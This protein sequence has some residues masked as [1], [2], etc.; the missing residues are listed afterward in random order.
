MSSKSHIVKRALLIS[1]LERYGITSLQ[2]ISAIILARLL[3]PEDIG[4]YTVGVAVIGIAHVIRDFGV[5]QYL[6]QEKSLTREKVASALGLTMTFA[7]SLGAL[8]AVSAPY[9]AAYYEEPAVE[10]VLFVVVLNFLIIPL[11][12][13]APALLKRSMSFGTLFKINLAAATV[14][15]IVSI[16]LAYLGFG[17]MSMAWATVANVAVGALMSQIYLPKKYRVLPSLSDVK[18]ILNFGGHVVG[19]NIVVE[20][21]TSAT[22]LIVGKYLG[23]TSL[24]LLSRAQGYLKM[25]TN[26]I[27]KA[28]GPVISAHLAKIYRDDEGIN[29]T[30]AYVINYVTLVGWFS[31][32]FMGLMGSHIIRILYGEQW[33][34]AAPLASLLCLIACINVPDSLGSRLLIATGRAKIHFWITI[35]FFIFR[36]LFIIAFVSYGLQTMLVSLLLLSVFRLLITQGVIWTIFDIEKKRF[37]KILAKNIA[38]C[39]PITST[40]YIFLDI[41]RRTQIALNHLGPASQCRHRECAFSHNGCIF[42]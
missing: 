5:G 29:D 25:Y 8:L 18:P 14:S 15:A 9:I 33:D 27:D 42:H 3:T 21:N 22:D 39:A 6:L 35:I 38:N 16:S 12:A 23:F 41:H 24:G 11:G 1:F 31:L 19:A 32:G 28:T 30:Y 4:I 7:W 40:S 37:V 2:L 10:K 17:F 36:L 13:M 34:M 26:I 20:V